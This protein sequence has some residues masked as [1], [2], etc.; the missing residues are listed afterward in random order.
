MDEF[1][2]FLTERLTGKAPEY[3]AYETKAPVKL[4][5]ERV[6]FYLSQ[7]HRSPENDEFWGS[8][9]TEWNNV[10][11]A[12]PRFVGHYQ[13]RLPGDLGFYDLTVE[14]NLRR[15]VAMAKNYGLTGFMFY[16]YWFGG[17]TVLEAPTRLFLKRKDL[18]FKFFLMWANE[19]WTR[20]WDGK[21]DQLLLKQVY[22]E[23]EPEKFIRYLCDY[24]EDERYIRVDGRPVLGVYRAS[25]IPNVLAVTER[26]REACVKHGF[27]EPYLISALTFNEGDPRTLGFDAAIEFPPHQLTIGRKEGPADIKKRL[28][29][30]FDSLGGHIYHYAGMIQSQLSLLP[31][32]YRLYRTAFP[33]WDNTARRREN[34]TLFTGGTPQ[35]FTEWTTQLLRD[36]LAGGHRFPMVCF[37]AWNEWA[38]GAYL[39]PDAYYGYAY[40]NALYNAIALVA[41]DAQRPAK[42][43]AVAR[44]GR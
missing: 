18:D 2:H 23:D 17:K 24:L 25:E 35:M 38:E 15:Q 43:K 41:A 16:F 36:E 10:V 28:L 33:G 13:P 42:P 8:G 37:N 21:E 12:L 20:R 1:Y 32:D 39:E 3:K 9:F 14:D 30:F 5:C 34:A 22:A 7:F 6:A 27:K 11:R 19:N 26:W 44:S 4:E 40:L 31:R 29:P